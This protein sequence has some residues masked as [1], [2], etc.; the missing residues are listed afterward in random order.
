[1]SLRCS[2]LYFVSVNNIALIPQTKHAYGR[3]AVASLDEN[4][5]VSVIKAAG[6]IN[7]TENAFQKGVTALIPQTKH[8]FGRRA[9][10]SLDENECASVI[11]AAALINLAYNPSQRGV[12]SLIPQ[13]KHL[14]GR[15]DGSEYFFDIMVV[16]QLNQMEH[17]FKYPPANPPH[18]HI[19]PL[20]LRILNI[21]SYT[22]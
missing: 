12:N 6:L 2:Y 10:A 9:V 11:E 17:P 15:R 21:S 3:R 22:K 8:P 7:L 20:T 5:C 1:M 4:E 19:H 14:F 13:P 18:S 16:A